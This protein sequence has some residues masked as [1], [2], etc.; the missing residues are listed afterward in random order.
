MSDYLKSDST[1]IT[2]LTGRLSAAESQI[3]QN[4]NT[5]TINSNRLNSAETTIASNTSKITN[6][7]NDVDN[8]TSRVSQNEANTSENANKITQHTSAISAAQDAIAA[9][10]ANFANYP[11][12]AALKVAFGGNANDNKTL[13][14]NINDQFGQFT[15]TSQ[16]ADTIID[17][18]DSDTILQNKLQTITPNA[19]ANYTTTANLASTI[20]GT[21]SSGAT[22]LTT[23]LKTITPNALANYTTTN[24]LKTAFGGSSSAT[25]NTIISDTID[26]ISDT[27]NGV[28]AIVY[29]LKEDN[30]SP[31]KT[32]TTIGNI[33]DHFPPEDGNNLLIQNALVLD[34]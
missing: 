11:N 26:D 19:L 6:T 9:N 13:T 2:S 25:L 15:K 32:N 10:T 33:Y 18:I 24:D 31:F 30:N 3:T 7:E 1:V 29:V 23:A 5:I 27:K 12:T 17:Y 16:L 14:E 20:A 22:N 8:L 21:I 28:S 4:T 34:P